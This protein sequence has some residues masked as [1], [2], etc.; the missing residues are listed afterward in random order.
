MCGRFTLQIPPELLAGIF[1]LTTFPVVPARYNIAPTPQIVVIRT[2][3]PSC[4]KSTP[5]LAGWSS[6]ICR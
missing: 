3:H 1:G 4:N 2:T 6:V 5:A